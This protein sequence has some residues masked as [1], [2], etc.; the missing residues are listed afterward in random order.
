MQEMECIRKYL[1]SQGQRFDSLP[2]IGGI[3]LDLPA[4]SRAISQ[5]GGIHTVADDKRKWMKI[6]DIL[7]I[8]KWAQDR[9]FKLYD[10]YCRFLISYDSLPAE[11]K[12]KLQQQVLNDKNRGKLSMDCV[13]KGRS[14][15]LAEFFNSARSTLVRWFDDNPSSAEV[16][17]EYWRILDEQTEHVA[18]HSAH[19]DTKHCG[20]GFPIKKDSPYAKHGWN[21]NVLQHSNAHS[22]LRHLGSVSG[23]TIP[24]LHMGMLFST[25]CWCSDP[26][27][28]PYISYLHT[29]SDII[30]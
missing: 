22:V 25:N 30:W 4:L 19:V 21:F 6:A 29:G 5:L 12:N 28:L 11:D 17:S 16:E 8:P 20:G 14:R 1:A 7:R 10:A 2:M 3:E 26:H 23:V 15:S 18:V 24:E 9:S 13:L 27:G